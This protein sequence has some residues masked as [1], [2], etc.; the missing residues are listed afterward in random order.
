MLFRS[1]PFRWPWLTFPR[2]VPALAALGVLVVVVAT[3]RTRRSFVV[4]QARRTYQAEL[5]MDVVGPDCGSVASWFRGRV[6]FPVHAP[7]MPRQ[8]TCQGGR[9]VN[10]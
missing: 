9:L 8:I 6:D 3:V 1:A 10:V 5:P 4:E 7:R 2:L